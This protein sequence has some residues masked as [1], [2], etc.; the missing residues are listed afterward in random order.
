LS[1]RKK[2]DVAIV[3]G[4]LV[5]ASLACALEPLGL[6][7]V[8]LEKTPPRAVNQPS[9]D[10]RT[11]ALSY[12]SCRIL[13]GLGLWSELAGHATAIREIIATELGRPG[14]VKLN[15]SEMGLEAFGHVVEARA[16]GSVV[17]ERLEGLNGVTVQCPATVSRVEANEERAIITLEETGEQ[18]EAG[19]VVA[20]DGA[21]S[22]VREMLGIKV[23][24]RDYEQTAV[25]C[26]ITPEHPHNG[27]AFERLTTT[28]P[29]AV[30]PHAGK[31]CGLVWSMKSEDVSACMEMPEADFLKAAH[32]RFGNELGAFVKMGRRSSYPLKLVR[33][34][35]DIDQRVVV[36]GNAAHAIHPIGAQ[37]FNLGLRDV[38]VLAEV[39]AES[40]DDDVGSRSILTAY[41]EWR[42]PDQES[43]VAWSDGMTRM[44]AS[45]APLM[46]TI[47]SV[48]MIAHAL[49]PS[50]RRRL[51]SSAM[52]YRGRV[53]KLAVGEPF[54]RPGNAKAVSQS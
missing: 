14:R 43:T 36:I 20:A 54:Q 50:L 47:R 4:G 25:I 13:E 16:F 24:S 32:A 44:F 48:G 23:R 10:D 19:L 49:V 11:L 38:A 5:G 26:N 8:V 52:G 31:R 2:F 9:Y 35:Q 33:A 15:A 3:G 41:S 37:G 7:I 40:S 21:A 17:L 22:A 39:L 12:S 6:R 45:S 51:A 53:P 29:F 28:G 1:D 18:L 42:R 46:A 27:R 34:L 30:L